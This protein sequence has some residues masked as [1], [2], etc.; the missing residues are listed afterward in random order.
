MKLHNLLE[1][2]ARQAFLSFQQ[3]LI[4]LDDGFEQA[5]TVMT[6]GY[7]GLR[8]NQDADVKTF[9]FIRPEASKKHNIRFIDLTCYEGSGNVIDYKVSTFGRAPP[10]KLVGRRIFHKTADSLDQIMIYLDRVINVK[11]GVYYPFSG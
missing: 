8:Y 4:A 10:G 5:D 1:D 6:I 11:K 9:H 2:T 3:R 7:S